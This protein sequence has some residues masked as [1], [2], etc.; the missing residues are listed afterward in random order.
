VQRVVRSHRLCSSRRA[1]GLPVGGKAPAG[2]R[3]ASSKIMRMMS[4]VRSSSCGR[5]RR[6][7]V[8]AGR[9]CTHQPGGRR[10]ARAARTVSAQRPELEEVCVEGGMSRR[11]MLSAVAPPPS[12]GPSSCVSWSILDAARS[13]PD[14]KPVLGAC[15]GASRYRPV[16]T[17][18]AP[19]HGTS[20]WLR[21]ASVD[22]GGQRKSGC[23]QG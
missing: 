2:G 6:V 7:S 13:S 20:S 10:V 9:A 11:P 5:R 1:R 4:L 16:H 21:E 14:K 22:R 15:C 17:R 3:G 19:L 23:G 18:A 8:W 12:S